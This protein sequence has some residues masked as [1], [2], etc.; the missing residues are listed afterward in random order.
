MV[1]GQFVIQGG[2]TVHGVGTAEGVGSGK[3]DDVPAEFEQSRVNGGESAEE[4]A[5]PEPRSARGGGGRGYDS[6]GAFGE[7]EVVAGKALPQGG[8]AGKWGLRQ[9]SGCEEGGQQR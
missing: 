7:G 6:D 5:A 1:E 9:A 8:R 2:P 3:I 4:L